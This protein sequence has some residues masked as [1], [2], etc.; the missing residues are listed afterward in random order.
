R[1]LFRSHVTRPHHH[2]GDQRPDRQRYGDQHHHPQRTTLVGG[3][4]RG[5]RGR[6]SVQ[7]PVPGAAGVPGGVGVLLGILRAGHVLGCVGH[8]VTTC[9]GRRGRSEERRGGA[10]G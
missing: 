7:V 3:R 5:R 2:Q 9:P 1:V 8:V 4:F 10:G 6:R